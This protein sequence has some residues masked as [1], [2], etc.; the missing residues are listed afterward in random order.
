MNQIRLNLLKLLPVFVFMFPLVFLIQVF[1]F[2]PYFGN[3]DDSVNAPAP[4]KPQVETLTEETVRIC[5]GTCP[6]DHLAEIRSFVPTKKSLAPFFS[7]P[8]ITVG[9]VRI[10]A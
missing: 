1:I 8:T 10:S 2:R 6:I 5:I 3:M 7:A 9:K 4:S